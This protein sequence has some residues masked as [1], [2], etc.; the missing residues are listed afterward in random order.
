M[1]RYWL[2]SFILLGILMG[3]MAQDC[4]QCGTYQCYTTPAE[5]P[6]GTVTDMCDCCLVCAKDEDEECGGLWDMRG[7]C[8]EGLTCVKE[9]GD[10]ENSVGVCKKE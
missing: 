3:G 8:G 10:D 2:I 7:K 5:C 9:N 4:M 6:A 1:N